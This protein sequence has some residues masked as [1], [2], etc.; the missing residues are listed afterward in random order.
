MSE[1]WQMYLR[2]DPDGDL[3]ILSDVGLLDEVDSVAPAGLFRVDLPV[4]SEDGYPDEIQDD[5]LNTIEDDLHPQLEALGGLY[6]GR[7]TRPGMRSLFYYANLT[8]A[9]VEV[10]V[11]KAEKRFRI[12]VGTYLGSD[13]EHLV[14]KR[15]LYPTPEEW[16]LIK[17]FGVF[18]QLG[19]NGDE[20]DEPREIRH[21]AYFPDRASAEGFAAEI[22]AS[23]YVIH[24]IGDGPP[25][26]PAKRMCIRFT[27][28]DT[29]A[30]G[31]FTS[32]NIEL[33]KSAE[34]HGGEYDGWETEVLRKVQ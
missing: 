13:P 8:E 30:Y 17:D 12:K 22:K 24:D 5:T 31:G 4:T 2:Q 19:E 26:R 1:K 10:L 11:R 9:Q 33:R 29:P 20:R 3:Y 18:E 23:G 21:W 27:R 32:A 7:I 6:V 25:D 34:R 15:M 28:E 14:Y 16:S